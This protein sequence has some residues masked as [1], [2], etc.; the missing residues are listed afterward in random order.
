[1]DHSIQI[2]TKTQKVLPKMRDGT[3]SIGLYRQRVR[4]GKPNCRCSRGE[5]HEGYSYL[6]WREE[7]RQKKIYI[8]L[9]LVPELSA[10]IDRL[11]SERQR[12][13]DDVRRSLEALRLMRTQLKQL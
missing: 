2:K 9:R 13:R 10:V 8:P 7:G 1:M 11:R 3:V 6:M 4:C 5:L 12:R